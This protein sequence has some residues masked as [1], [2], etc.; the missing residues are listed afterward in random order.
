MK[1]LDWP[2]LADEN[3]DRRLVLLLR[4]DGLD[5]V[6]VVD[7][8]LT[9]ASDD[10]VLETASDAGRPPGRSVRRNYGSCDM[11]MGQRTERIAAFS[12]ERARASRP[13][14]RGGMKRTGRVRRF[15][16]CCNRFTTATRSPSCGGTAVSHR[17]SS[18]QGRA[19]RGPVIQRA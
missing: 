8:G 18:V 6:T 16:P 1:A 5:I 7:L 12:A 3:I 19:R 10:I 17:R 13:S 9:G 4:D 2:I 11:K 14:S 15:I